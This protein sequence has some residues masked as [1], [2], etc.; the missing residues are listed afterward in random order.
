MFEW[1][2]NVAQ[3]V[4]ELV[5]EWQLLEP[6]HG[7][8]RFRPGGKTDLLPPG[9]VYWYW[10]TVM[11]ILTIPIKRQTLS[12][13]QRLTTK[14]G[15]AISINTVIVYE[16]E[17]V[18]KALVDTHDFEDTIE[19]VAQKLTVQP[20]MSRSFDEI[21]TDMAES[22]DM[23]NELTRGARTLLSPYG[24][25]VLDSYVSDFTEVKVLYHE[26]DGLSVNYEE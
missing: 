25:R 15:V 26:G 17:D 8:V 10:P 9:R 1:I 18:R 14:D 13:N 3:W 11:T 6:T 5:P 16:I 22:N 4:S 12:F 23:R 21:R 19:E 24:T 7:G 20:V 2:N